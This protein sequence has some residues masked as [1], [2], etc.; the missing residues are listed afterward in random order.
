MQQLREKFPLIIAIVCG[1]LA[2]LLLNVYLRSREGELLSKIKQIQQQQAQATKK[3]PEKTAMVLLAKRDIPAQAE[4]TRNDIA[5]EEIP[6]KYIQPG[7][8]ASLDK[9]IGQ[10]ASTPITAR[11]QILKTKLLPADKIGKS[12]S[13]IM[14]E[15]KRAV[16]V[17]VDNIAS[18]AG[19]LKPGDYV[20]VFALIFPPPN[21]K[22]PEAGAQK[23]TSRLISLFQD[24][25][26]LAIGGKYVASSDISPREPRGTRKSGVDSEA[27][28]LALDPQ[29]AIL[30]S[31]VQEHG[32]IKLSLRSSEDTTI[33]SVKPADW[34]TLFKYLYPTQEWEPEVEREYPFVEI[35]RGTQKEV[36]T[37]SE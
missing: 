25:K 12:L 20:D 37:I 26:V 32:K 11:E 21:I 35:Y 23:T 10:I 19:L 28:T 5:I 15:G 17:V 6:V 8:L 13:E 1:I 27:V 36:M 33:E 9:V 2:I 18:L 7:A 14:P 22:W 34:D 29:E 31:F 4:I 3:P 30:L 24:V 16:T